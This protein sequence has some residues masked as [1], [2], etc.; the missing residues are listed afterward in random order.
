MVHHAQRFGDFRQPAGVDGGCL[1]FLS[2]V[3]TQ[4]AFDLAARQAV[5]QGIA[6]QRFQLAQGVGQ[7]KVRLQVALIDRA[8]LHLQGAERGGLLGAGKGGHAVD[9]TGAG[10]GDSC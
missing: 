9:V 10:H 4:A 2:G 8:N 6:Q 7:A 5:T 3:K 1:T